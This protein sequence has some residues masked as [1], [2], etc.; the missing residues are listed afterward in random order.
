MPVFPVGLD[1][2]NLLHWTEPGRPWSV[3]CAHCGEDYLHILN[4]DI[5]DG[6]TTL[7]F[8]CEIC[9]KQSELRF[10][11]NKGTLYIAATAINELAWS[12]L[13]V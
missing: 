12:D 8:G 13:A 9:G 4:T 2:R 1:L 10:E 6:R 5:K 11:F 3:G 7:T